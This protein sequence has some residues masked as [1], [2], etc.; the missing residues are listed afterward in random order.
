MLIDYCLIIYHFKAIINLQFKLCTCS[1][2]N[3]TSNPYVDDKCE[4]KFTSE[5]TS[6]QSF[7]VV[8]DALRGQ[9]HGIDRTCF[10][11]KVVQN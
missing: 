6:E 9:Y 10:I 3:N 4:N 7:F 11:Y 5:P 2:L 8:A 1:Q